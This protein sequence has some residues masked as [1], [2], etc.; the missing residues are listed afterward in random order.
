MVMQKLAD[1][2]Q[3]KPVDQMEFLR[4]ALEDISHICHGM[5]K[6]TTD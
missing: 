3:A 1:S 5:K 6:D 2:S 4:N